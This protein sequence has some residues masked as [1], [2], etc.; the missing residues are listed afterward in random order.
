MRRQHDRTKSTLLLFVGSA[1]IAYVTTYAV[2][3]FNSAL[4]SSNQRLSTPMPP[5]PEEALSGESLSEGA[6]SEGSFLAVNSDS[7]CRRVVG[8]SFPLYADPGQTANY[9]QTVNGGQQVGLENGTNTVVGGDGLPYIYVSVPYGSPNPTRGY[10]QSQVQ[11]ASTGNT[12]ST[13][14]LCP[15]SNNV[16]PPPPDSD[17]GGGPVGAYW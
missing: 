15:I 14:G 9:L 8:K 10:I 12:R 4:F 11:N 7:N 3:R 5:L 13:L 1:A 16:P 6:L 17:D 2:I